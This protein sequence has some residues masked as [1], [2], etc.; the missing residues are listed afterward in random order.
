[1]LV[2]RFDWREE[3]RRVQQIG[4]RPAQ[5]R[6]ELMGITKA[7]LQSDSFLSASSFQETPKVLT[8]AAL[9]GKTDN[10]RGLKENVILGRLVPAGTGFRAH[11]NAVVAKPPLPEGEEQIEAPAA[12]A[13]EKP[14]EA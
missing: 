12:P 4:G 13:A 14:A 7:S 3:N 6:P 9:A 1:M 5:A 10:L 8:E 11:L 2:D